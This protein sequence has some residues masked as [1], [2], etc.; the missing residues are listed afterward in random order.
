MDGCS[1]EVFALM[2]NINSE[3]SYIINVTYAYDLHID[4]CSDIRFM[5]F[6]IYEITKSEFDI[7]WN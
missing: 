7:Y 4:I 1:D 3:F 5:L 6:D 2:N